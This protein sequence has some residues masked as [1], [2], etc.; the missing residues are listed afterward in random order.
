MAEVRKKRA[1]LTPGQEM[2]L[3][4]LYS[5]HPEMTTAKLAEH[6]NIA[7]RTVSATV[8]R[9][10]GELRPGGGRQVDEAQRAQIVELFRD[11]SCTVEEIAAIVGCRRTTVYSVTAKMLSPEERR[12]V[13]ER[14]AG[15]RRKYRHR[16]DLFVE[17]L[18]DAELWLF[19]LL[20]ADGWVQDR[21]CVALSL[22]VRDRDA[23]ESARRVAGSDAPIVVR[24][25]HRAGPM[26][27]RGGPQALWTIRGGEIVTRVSA[28]GMVQAKSKR[29]DVRVHVDVAQSPSFWRG[30]IDGDGSI[31]WVRRTRRRDRRACLCVLGGRLLLEQWARFVVDSVGGPSPRVRATA[32]TRILHESVLTGSRAWR[33]LEVLYGRGGPALERKRKMALDIL[34]SPSPVPQRTISIG[35]VTLALDELGNLPLRD[36]PYRYVCPHTGVQ[37]GRLVADARDGKRPDLHDVFDRCDSKWRVARPKPLTPVDLVKLAL[38]ELG[39][40]PLRDV[41]YRYVCAH[42]R[43][44]L[45]ALLHRAR[46]GGRADLHKLFDRYDMRWRGND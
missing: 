22:S 19:G 45:G 42:T 40:L 15:A 21:W 5:E 33:M 17:P 20:M 44:R 28:L 6:F 13:M 46:R 9:H 32:G 12:S 3:A 24:E 43:V 2:E 16:P 11:S 30:L 36:V 38:D 26:G 27:I 4:E 35:L 34:A 31:G 23:I 18:S 25:S 39:H 14:R 1:H 7:R 8:R 29:E 41:P 10:G 37:L